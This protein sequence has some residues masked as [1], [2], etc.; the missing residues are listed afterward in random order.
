MPMEPAGLGVKCS[1][2]IEPPD[3]VGFLDQDYSCR[4]VATEILHKAGLQ[5][6]RIFGDRIRDHLVTQL[7]ALQRWIIN[8]Q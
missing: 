7:T 1:Q 3:F 8:Y 5:Q 4:S 2:H 6:V